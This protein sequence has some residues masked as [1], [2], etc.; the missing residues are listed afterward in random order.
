MNALHPSIKDP[1][2]DVHKFAFYEKPPAVGSN[3]DELWVSVS[4]VFTLEESDQVIDFVDELL[5][6]CPDADR[7]LLQKN[8]TQLNNALVHDESISYYS[9]KSDSLDSVLDIFIRVNSGGAVLSKSDLLFSTIVCHW[10]NAREQIDSLLHRINGV[11]HEFA[12]SSDF[13]VRCCL[14]LSDLP[15]RLRVDSLT[16]ANVDSFKRNWEKISDAI[17]DTRKLLVDIGFAGKV[18]YSYNAIIPLVYYVYKGGDTKRDESCLEIKKYIFV[19]QYKQIFGRANDSVLGNVCKALRDESASG[20]YALK[21]KRFSLKSLSDAMG[22]KRLVLDDETLDSIFLQEKNAYTMMALVLLCPEFRIDDKQF[23]Q[24]HLHPH[25]LFE[26]DGLDSFGLTDEQKTEWRS[27]RNMLPNLQ[28]LI[29]ADNTSKNATPFDV[30]LKDESNVAS[31]RYLPQH[32]SYELKDFE[33]FFEERKRLMRD[34]LA[35]VFQM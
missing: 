27:K 31:V 11:N 22:D 5:K 12:F 33:Q 15:V 4:D 24:D 9:M 7:K 35:K 16:K 17:K 25:A 8:T 2:S 28:L 6:A 18:I 21:S 34:E 3:D 29:G 13:V 32:C 19:A 14:A 23:H 20:S 10:D 1:D 30:W 26:G